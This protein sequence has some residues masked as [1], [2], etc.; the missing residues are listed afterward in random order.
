MKKQSKDEDS[1]DTTCCVTY[2]DPWFA[3]QHSR[4][5]EAKDH[6]LSP[7]GPSNRQKSSGPNQ[8]KLIALGRGHHRF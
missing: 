7:D 8:L 3:K 6:Q 4:N 2:G 1:T 5:S